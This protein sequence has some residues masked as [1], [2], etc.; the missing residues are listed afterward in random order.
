MSDDIL[1]QLPA[2]PEGLRLMKVEKLFLPHPYCIGAKHVAHAADHFSGMLGEAAIADGEK[3][4]IICETCK[5][6][7]EHLSYKDH[8]TSLTLFVEIP[9]IPR[10]EHL[11]DVPGLHEYLLSI[12]E[13]A[14]RLGIQGFAFPSRK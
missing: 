2:P 11:K 4:G 14:E 9:P 12:K 13:Q 10:L 5:A 1:S 7:G 3:Q 6:R 8:E